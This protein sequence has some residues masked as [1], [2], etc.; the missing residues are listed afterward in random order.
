M[1]C[2]KS[3]LLI[4]DK[5][6]QVNRRYRARLRAREVLEARAVEGLRMVSAPEPFPD[7]VEDPDPVP[8]P[9]PAPEPV[10]MLE[11]EPVQP[12]PEKKKR[13]RKKRNV[14]SEKKA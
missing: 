4:G 7:L 14:F 8:A 6:S 2:I 5:N 9:L 12:S 13:K 11:P 3:D 1:E 10:L